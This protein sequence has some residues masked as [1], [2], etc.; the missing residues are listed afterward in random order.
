MLLSQSLDR[1]TAVANVEADPALENTTYGIN[2]STE[3][4]SKGLQ[5]QQATPASPEPQGCCIHLGKYSIKKEKHE[6]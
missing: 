4:S 2:N 5:L 3:Y 1:L 6:N